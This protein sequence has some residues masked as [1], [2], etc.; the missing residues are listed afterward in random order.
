MPATSPEAIERKNA[1]KREKRRQL[2]PIIVPPQELVLPCY[3][4][5]ARRMMPRLP[6]MTK[7]ELREMLTK[8]V[9]NT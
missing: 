2:R 1:R 3:K 5:T 8:A 6:D 7:A 4:V 9:E